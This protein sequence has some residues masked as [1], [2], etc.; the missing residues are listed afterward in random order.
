[1]D[2]SGSVNVRMFGV[3]GAHRRDAGL[4]TTATLEIPTAGLTAREL[5]QMLDL[6]IESIEGAFINHV[7]RDLS[8]LVR[9]GD[10]VAFVPHGTPGPHRYFLGLFDAGTHETDDCQQ[11]PNGGSAGPVSRRVHPPS[12]VFVM[13]DAQTKTT[14][15]ETVAYLPMQ[16]PFDQIPSA[17]GRLYGW[18]ASHGLD[19]V[20]MPRCTYLDDPSTTPPAEARWELQAPVAQGSPLADLDAQGIGVKVV[21]PHLVA[22]AMHRG[23]YETIGET[24]FGVVEWI[25]AHGYRI[26][27]PAYEIYY[28]DPEDT[29]PADY[30]TEARVP[31]ARA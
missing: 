7:I 21:E 13:T 20:G 27:G 16:G 29:E 8:Q 4:P 14:E 23:P 2:P 5:A 6:P 28:S 30:L 24:Y 18:V 3:L 26:D 9:P 19:A 10:K 12:E 25:D 17:M 1:M 31:I 11:V 15:S 22:F